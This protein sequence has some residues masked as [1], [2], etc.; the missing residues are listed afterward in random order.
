[1]TP[2][3]LA[4]DDVIHATDETY[5]SPRLENDFNL[6]HL[7]GQININILTQNFLMAVNS[8]NSK[9]LREVTTAKV[10]S[11]H[12]LTPIYFGEIGAFNIASFQYAS[13]TSMIIQSQKWEVEMASTAGGFVMVF[14]TSDSSTVN[15]NVSN[16]Y[17]D[18]LNY[19]ETR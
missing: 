9:K 11:A 16:E 18:H 8:K 3:V 4:V 7:Y 10:H 14:E 17:F 15:A 6:N 12:F 5:L 1:M 19:K 2:L 13:S